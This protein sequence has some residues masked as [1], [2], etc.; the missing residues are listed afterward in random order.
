MRPSRPSLH[1]LYPRIALLLSAVFFAGLV[2]C[3]PASDNTPNIGPR[4]SVAGPP[5]AQ[6]SS[7]PRNDSALPLASP[8]PLASDNWNVAASGKGGIPSVDSSSQGDRLQSQSAD[9]PNGKSVP[10]IPDSIIKDLNSP[11]ARVR[12]QA[13]SHWG[14]KETTAPLDPLFEAVDDEDPAVQA[15]AIEIIERYWAAEQERERS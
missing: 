10:L 3:G 8:M 5:L 2:S 14:S 4:A 7:A 12:L 15:K 11:D 1:L 9:T 6:K 13:M